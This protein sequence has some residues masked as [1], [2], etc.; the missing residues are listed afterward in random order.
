[1]NRAESTAELLTK[2]HGGK[3]EGENEEKSYS[4]LGLVVLFTSLLEYMYI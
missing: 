2:N 4:T 1:M 3:N